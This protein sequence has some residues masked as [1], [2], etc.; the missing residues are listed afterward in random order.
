MS[1]CHTV[2]SEAVCPILTFTLRTSR[3]KLDP[4]RVTASDPV[5]TVL[6]LLLM[7]SMPT[8]ADA[9]IDNVPTRPPTVS[10][11]FPLPKAP[12]PARHNSHESDIHVVLSH[13]DCV[14]RAVAV[15]TARLIPDPYRT[16]TD[17]PVAAAF[18]PRT[19][20]ILPMSQVCT[21]V[22]VPTTCP[23]VSDARRLLPDADPIAHRT[24]VSDSHDER[25]PAVTPALAVPLVSPRPIPNP[26]IVMLA[27]PVAARFAR[28]PLLTLGIPNDSPR[29]MLLIR[30]PTVADTRLLPLSATPDAAR[31]VSDVSDC[32]TAPSHAVRPSAAAPD[33]D[34]DPI[35]LPCIVRVD[36]PVVTMFCTRAPLSLTLSA[37]KPAVELPVRRPADTDTRRLPFAPAAPD[38]HRTE[39]SDAHPAVPSHPDSPVLALTLVVDASPKPAPRS[40]MLTEPV[41]PALLRSSALI[42]SLS[43]DRPLDKLP[44]AAPAVIDT[45]RLRDKP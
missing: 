37:E 2:L 13:L 36:D 24:E 20:L 6:V 10:A 40:V 22:A 42:P 27:D 43:T 12:R 18:D 44:A 29:V 5:V 16:S 8:S 17:D 31:H 25:S 4:C 11:A 26:A 23:A 39:V 33:L 14:I 35:P 32:H 3:P 28:K 19:P 45:R 41:A 38:L 34:I 1:D 21:P 7:L 30:A 15:D 9:P